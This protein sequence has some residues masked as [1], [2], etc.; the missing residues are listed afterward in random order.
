MAANIIELISREADSGRRN[1]IIAASL[2]GLSNAFILA[3]VNTVARNSRNV[4]LHVFVLYAASIALYVM[5]SRY[6]YHRLTQLIEESLHHIKLRIVD[7]IRRMDLQGFERMGNSEIYDRVTDNVGVVSA[8]A[9]MLAATLQSL[10]VLTCS[11]IYLAWLSMPAFVITVMLV[12]TGTMILSSNQYLLERGLGRLTG[13]R[14]AFFEQL[15]D[16]LKGFKETRFN[17]RRSQDLREDILRSSAHLRDGINETNNLLN[18]NLI[19]GNCLLFVALGAMVFV[20]PQQVPLKAAELTQIVSAL[21]FTWSSIAIALSC[22]SS[23]MRSNFALAEIESLEKKLDA[24]ADPA[25]SSPAPLSP[26]PKGISRIEVSQLEYTYEA[27]SD[28]SPAFHI[29]PVDL[30]LNAGEVLFIVGGNGSG[31]S[32]FLKVLTGLYPASSGAIRVDGV[33]VTSR[34]SAAYRELICTI[35]TDFHLF[36]RL[37]GLLDVP[38]E[39]VQGLISQMELSEQTGYAEQRFTRRELST[40]QRKRLAMIVA[41]LEDR[42]IYV[43]DEWAADQDP[44]FRHYFYMELLPLLRQRGKTVIAVSHDDRYF[45]YA[46]RVLTMEYGKVRSLEQH[47]ADPA[48]PPP[49]SP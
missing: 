49:K 5:S 43:F 18:D 2:S 48:S 47:L 45:R 11:A 19:Y 13:S 25:S 36:S 31:K 38:S 4:G 8:S 42:P 9:G 34:T 3:L 35:F 39:A 33:A 17:A 10:C 37:Y 32:T 6:T 12:A 20:L 44:V 7:K 23:Y 29:G 15:T 46:D 14:V 27:R 21:M 26:W 1:L 24:G 40:G 22:Y 30:T 41:L 16:L 28:G